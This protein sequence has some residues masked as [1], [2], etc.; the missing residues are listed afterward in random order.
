MT[1]LFFIPAFPAL[2]FLALAFLP[3]VWRNRLVYLGPVLVGVSAV[4]AVMGFLHYYPGGEVSHPFLTYSWALARMGSTQL[5]ISFKIDSLAILMLAMVS[6]VGLCVQIYSLFYM[7]DDERRGWYFC[8]LLLFT[9]AMLALVAS[10][11]L[12]LMFA[13]WELMGVC[14]YLLIGFW[15]TKEEPRRASI[16]AFLVTRAGDVGFFIALAVIY[17]A[18][19]SFELSTILRTAPSWPAASVVT[20]GICLL[21]AAAGKSAQL[22]LS[23]WLP[24]AMAGPTP[25]SAIIHAATMVAAGIFV[26]ARMMPVLAQS[27]LVLHIALWVG[28]ITAIFGALLAVFQTDIKRILAFSTISQ[29]GLMFAALGIGSIDAAI[30]HLITHAFFKS[31][32]FLAAGSIIHATG[33]QDIRKMGGLVRRM[34]IISLIFTVGALSL[35]GVVPL[36]GFFSKDAIFESFLVAHQPV[37]FALGLLMAALTALY[38]A[39]TWLTVFFG[40]AHNTEAHEGALLE[41]IPTGLL[42]VF[43]LLLGFTAKSWLGYLDVHVEMPTIPMATISTGVMIVGAAAGFFLYLRHIDNDWFAARSPRLMKALDARL[44][45][46][47]FYEKVIVGPYFGLSNLFWSLDRTVI[48]GVVNAA[49]TSYRRLTAFAWRA[50]AHGID[51]AVNTLAA[52]VRHA[53][54][55]TR[56][57]ETGHVRAYQRFTVGAVILLIIVLFAVLILKGAM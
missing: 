24:D 26:L 51:G 16:K 5:L 45:T 11:N 42:A 32:L 13:A 7:K 18:C 25:A 10:G 14:S 54:T 43:T 12:L 6:I 40:D 39:K 49:A 20:V 44:Y 57:V 19:G 1:W 4:V 9:A 46:D 33:T 15:Y 48:D 2:G 17:G 31:L 29:L 8:V 21:W 22:P 56:K 27:A 36:S 3:R 35:A 37:V 38:V 55:L 41:I 23:V 53:S 30:F 28:I 50:D 47:A 34:P 52:T